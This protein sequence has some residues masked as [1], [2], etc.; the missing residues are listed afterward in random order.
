MNWQQL[1][2]RAELHLQLTEAVS[3]PAIPGVYTPTMQKQVV[4]VAPEINVNV[5]GAKQTGTGTQPPTVGTAPAVPQ[6][7]SPFAMPDVSSNQ[8]AA[9]LQKANPNTSP[10]F[11]A[12]APAFEDAGKKYNI[13]PRFLAAVAAVET[14]WGSSRAFRQGNNVMGISD[15]KGPLG[16]YGSAANSI[17]K[18]AA[19]LAGAAGTSGYY[20]GVNTISDIA[21]IY[22]P[23][24]ASNDP[25]GTNPQ[26]PSLV[27][28]IYS[29][30]GG[31]PNSPVK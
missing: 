22:A 26:W 4:D 7:T 24:G 9:Q 25:K 1:V 18:Q 17:Y 8:L 12:L 10:E 30:L 16:G 2:Q 15:A 5:P 21:R 6:S 28:S 13:D 27:G 3:L 19:S 31:D 23:S 14:G 29:K 20:K 11:L